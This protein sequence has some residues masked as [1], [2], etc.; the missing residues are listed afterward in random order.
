M[1]LP[2][3]D[4]YVL[5]ESILGQTFMSEAES[6]TMCGYAENR[7][8][9]SSIVPGTP[10]TTPRRR[11]SKTGSDFCTSTL[12]EVVV[13]R[14]PRV[15]HIYNVVEY[16]RRWYRQLIFSSDPQ[17]A[18]NEMQLSRQALNS[19]I[20][21]CSGDSSVETEAAISLVVTKDSLEE[22]SGR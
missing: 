7:I 19:T 5:S 11:N 17:I 10:P 14:Y 3:V 18:F 21:E 13:Y 4:L 1:V 9:T 8:E 12:K 6:I 20:L 16:G 22:G 2:G 15:F